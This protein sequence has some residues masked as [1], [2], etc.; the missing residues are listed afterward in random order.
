MLM[1]EPIREFD[2]FASDY[3]AVHTESMKLTGAESEYYCEF[4]VRIL[5]EMITDPVGRLL[6]YGC[7][8]GAVAPYFLRYFPDGIYDGVDVSSES[9]RQASANQLPGCGFSVT[10]GQRLS[11]PSASFDVVFVANVFHHIP[12]NEQA[13]IMREL[14][15]V[16]RPGGRI[17]V[18]EHNP[19]NPVTRYLVSICPF[20]RDARLLRPAYLRRL[21]HESGASD[22]QI[23]HMLFFPR[24]KFFS[25]LIP[26][27]K[28]LSFLPAGAQ[29]LINGT[30]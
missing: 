22:L 19:F 1:N 9:I 20:D 12:R 21:M 4:K 2:Q 30:R 11:F 26:L 8:D 23:H 18:F 15:R 25:R 10:D 27:E 28:W 7:G 17:F 16:L 5:R 14:L 13:A 3:R 24:H 29:Y 6:D